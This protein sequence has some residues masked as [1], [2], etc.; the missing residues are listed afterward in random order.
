MNYTIKFST[1]AIIIFKIYNKSFAYNLKGSRFL[2]TIP[3]ASPRALFALQIYL[4]HL[5]KSI[6]I[7]ILT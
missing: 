5:F 3:I 6:K 7:K 2:I 1:K 4:E